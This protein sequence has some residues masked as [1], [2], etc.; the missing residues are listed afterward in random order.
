MK[1]YVIAEKSE[2][3]AI[4]D[5]IRD[6]IGSSDMYGIGEI[7]DAIRSIEGV[8]DKEVVLQD[9]DIVLNE[10]DQTSIQADDGYDGLGLVNVNVAAV[11]RYDGEISSEPGTLSEVMSF[12]IAYGDTA[13]ADTS[14]LW[15]KTAEPN[16]VEVTPDIVV[17]GEEID[18]G[19]GELP[20]RAYS[21]APAVIGKKAYLFGGWDTANNAPLSTIN[22]FDAKTNM[23]NTLDVTLPTA[24]SHI[25]SAVVGTKVYLFGGVINWSST[26]ELNTINVFDTE[27]NTI[28]TLDTKL[29]SKGH[30]IAVASVGTKIYLFGGRCQSSGNGYWYSSIWV[31]DTEAETI[32]TLSKNLPKQICGMAAAT[33]GTKIY[34]FGGTCLGSSYVDIA[35]SAIYEFDTKNTSITTLP[36]SL[37]N[38]A[39]DIGVAAISSK[40][41]LFGGDG[42]AGGSHLNTIRV[43]DSE[44]ETISTLDTV[45]P[46]ATG[47]IATALIGAEVYLFG[48][49]YAGTP[50]NRF[51]AL[52]P[53]NTNKLL[54][55]T[56]IGRNLF[57]LIAGKTVEVEIGIKNV[58]LGNSEGYAEKAPAA[59]YVDGAW[60]EI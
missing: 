19:V 58:Y 60:E 35:Q 57:K 39:H 20:T 59:L 8:V 22:V 10:G 24:A 42:G 38:K 46:V 14:K 29:P 45:L 51:V 43:F 27:T 55:E 25:A 5:A 11:D 26:G 40:I 12:N 15:V 36:V 41:Y 13:P 37:P 9:K 52:L 2:L 54:I 31:F 7:P 34:L 56:A 47:H 48:G 23:L 6:K 32:T 18:I 49:Y 53:L 1:E 28:K 17:V 21:I 33:V 4:A 30:S 16:N 44:T 50:F 3:T